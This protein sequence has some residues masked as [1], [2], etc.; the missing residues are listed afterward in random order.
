MDC[1]LAVSERINMSKAKEWFLKCLPMLIVL[2]STGIFALGVKL[3][4]SAFYAPK[5]TVYEK[6]YAGEKYVVVHCYQRPAS[7][8][9]I[10]SGDYVYDESAHDNTAGEHDNSHAQGRPLA[11]FQLNDT[12]IDVESAVLK[13]LYNANGLRAFQFGEFV[14]YKLEG[15]YG[16]FAPLRDYDKASTDRKNDLYVIRQLMKS[17]AY[18]LF[19][20]PEWESAKDFS[21]NLEKIEWYLDTKYIEDN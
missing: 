10:Y 5:D 7:D 16:V 14:V 1:R 11:M 2:I 13:E 9:Y 19:D 3:V 6:E 21:K 20:L 17:E 18:T 8:Y 15:S 12:P 4:I